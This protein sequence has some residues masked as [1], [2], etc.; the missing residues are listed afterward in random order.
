MREKRR[1]REWTERE[2]EILQEHYKDTPANEIAEMLPGRTVPAINNRAQK[3]GLVKLAPIDQWLVPKKLEKLKQMFAETGSV[4]KVARKI[5]INKNTL[6]GWMA[7]Y[8]DISQA[9]EAGR[10]QYRETYKPKAKPK[11]KAVVVKP[12]AKELRGKCAT[13]EWARPLVSSGSR[14]MCIWPECVKE[15]GPC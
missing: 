8:I 12:Q 3:L 13:C 1:N 2:L 4:T 11:P 7:R 6:G 10:A 14:V 5:G 9:V 15:E